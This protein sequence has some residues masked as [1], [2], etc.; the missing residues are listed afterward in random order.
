MSGGEPFRHI[1]DIALITWYAENNRSALSSISPWS[2]VIVLFLLVILVT[3]LHWLPALFIVYTALLGTCVLA[4]LPLF[5]IARW[6]FLPV[7]FVLSLV[8]MI[9]WGE[10]GTPLFSISIAGF[11]A[12]LTDAGLVLVSVL[13]MKTL[14][15]V[16]YSFLVLMTTRYEHIAAIIDRLF[17]DP[18]NQIFLL[19]YRFLF[20]TI[21]LT[22]S[23]LKAV[24]S[25][26]GIVI[27][28][29]KA[30]AR[31]FAQVFALTFI[32]SLDR[33]ERIHAAMSARGYRG[34]YATA[35][36][37]P[38]PSPAGILCLLLAAAGTAVLVAGSETG[39]FGGHP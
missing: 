18:V 6:Y 14:I 13:L 16:T 38:S 26:G 10:P 35:T 1:P 4:R 28:S 2:K 7:L 9:A 19:S 15:I 23:L 22:G 11:S 21:E 32:R 31:L 24:R 29:A 17:P 20:L 34:V 37:I 5:R 12:T 27:S 8:G 3:V 25:R 30:Q 39:L 36:T 33:A